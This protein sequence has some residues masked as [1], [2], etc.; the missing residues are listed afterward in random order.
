MR[1][2]ETNSLYAVVYAF[3]LRCVFGVWSML[4]S[5]LVPPVVCLIS[6]GKGVTRKLCI[7]AYSTFIAKHFHLLDRRNVEILLRLLYFQSSD[8]KHHNKRL[9][10]K[11]PILD[12]NAEV[13]EKVAFPGS[14]PRLLDK[15][16]TR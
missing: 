11:I 5:L 12:K 14:F 13:A 8:F 3:E 16:L 2:L 10:W 15:V 4:H 6:N 9:K 7:T 1:N